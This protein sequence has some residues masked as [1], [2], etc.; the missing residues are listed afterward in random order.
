MVDKNCVRV[1]RDSTR[2]AGSY[3]CE[4]RR[5][6]RLLCSDLVQVLWK[7]GN[8]VPQCE[9]AVLENLSLAG[10]GLFMGVYIPEG[11]EIEIVSDDTHLR[12]SVKQCRFRENGYVVGL[13]LH[14]ESRWAQQPNSNFWPKHLLDV[15][16]LE[17][18]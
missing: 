4:R 3:R 14:P 15:S 2:N 11:T 16:L 12:G 13:E 18:D 10:V 9:I 17:L 7:A 1:R 6:K 8:G 5:N